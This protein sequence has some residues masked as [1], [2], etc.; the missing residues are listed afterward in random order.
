[1][2]KKNL[3]KL[4][5]VCAFIAISANKTMAQ[6]QNVTINVII[7]NITSL[8]IGSS[9]QSATLTYTTASDYANGVSLSQ[10][11]AM[12]AIS[13]QPYSITVYASTDLVN[14]LN[15]IPV[16]DVTVTPAPSIANANATCTAQPIPTGAGSALQ[17]VHSTAGTTEQQY[18]LTYSTQSAPQTDFLGKPAGTY[19]TTLT[20]SITNP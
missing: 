19:T 2:S 1:M 3:C 9:F 4:L 18:D 15:S 7:N 10:P 20:Y 13:N 6:T 8:T 14:G 17:I 11:A 16:H 12:T 5:M